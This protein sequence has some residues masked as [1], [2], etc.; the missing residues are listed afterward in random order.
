MNSSGA[1]SPVARAKPIVCQLRDHV[2]PVLITTLRT[3]FHLGI[4]RASEASLSVVGTSLRDSSVVL[5]MI[6]IIMKL[7][8]RPPANSRELFGSQYKYNENKK[9]YNNCRKPS[10]DIVHKT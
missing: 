4:P 6:G 10:K 7:K 9:S 8:A 2:L 3:V 5:A 1:V